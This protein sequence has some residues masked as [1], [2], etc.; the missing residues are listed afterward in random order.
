M[1]FVVEPQLFAL[2]AVR[3]WDVVVCD[4]VEEMDLVLAQRESSC[5][6]VHR[7]IAPALVVEAAV[8]VECVEVIEIGWRPKPVQAANF[9]VGPLDQPSGT[10]RGRPLL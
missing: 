2:G 7:S 9:E 3:E 6:G 5:D 10:A 1:A 4:V 8:T